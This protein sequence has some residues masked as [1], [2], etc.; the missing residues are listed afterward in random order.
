MILIEKFKDWRFLWKAKRNRRQA[1]KCAKGDHHWMVYGQDR[2]RCYGPGCGKFLG[3]EIFQEDLCN[4]GKHNW[5]EV[6][7]GNEQCIDPG[8]G[9]WM[10][11]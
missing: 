8:C 4:Q 10:D 1:F 9:K 11:L 3:R 2:V 6:A 7:P 5:R